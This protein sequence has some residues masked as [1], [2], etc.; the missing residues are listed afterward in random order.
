MYKSLTTRRVKD[1][2]A[3]LMTVNNDIAVVS[4]VSK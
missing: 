2:V 4:P 1:G 3:I